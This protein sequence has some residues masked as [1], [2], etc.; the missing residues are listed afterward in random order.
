MNRDKKCIDIRGWGSSRGMNTSKESKDNKEKV[1]N[2][3]IFLGQ[4]SNLHISWKIS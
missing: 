4:K 1:I 3:G 2:T